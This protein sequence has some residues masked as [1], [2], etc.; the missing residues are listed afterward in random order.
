MRRRIEI[1]LSK[2]E[3]GNIQKITTKIMKTALSIV[4]NKNFRQ[5][6]YGWIEKMT[7]FFLFFYNQIRMKYQYGIEFCISISRHMSSMSVYTYIYFRIYA[8]IEFQWWFCC[9]QVWLI[10]VLGSDKTTMTDCIIAPLLTRRGK[11]RTVSL[12]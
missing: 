10:G 12:R 4:R 3:I 8:N 11:Q 7:K 1:P 9:C 5:L 2:E 6:L